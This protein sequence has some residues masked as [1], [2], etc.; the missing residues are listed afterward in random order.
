M[1]NVINKIYKK[2][3]NYIFNK[4]IR[5]MLKNGPKYTYTQIIYK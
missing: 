3:D 5:K 1:K 4:K 2:V